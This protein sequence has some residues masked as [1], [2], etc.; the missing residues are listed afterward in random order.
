MKIEI[1]YLLAERWRRFRGIT[2]RSQ[3]FKDDMEQQ[4]HTLLKDWQI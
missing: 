2:D 3:E 4:Y 1:N